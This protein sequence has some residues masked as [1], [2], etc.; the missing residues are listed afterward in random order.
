MAQVVVYKGN[1]DKFDWVTVAQA[2]ARSGVSQRSIRKWIKDRHIRTR[3]NISGIMVFRYGA[4]FKTY[5]R[6]IPVA[7]RV[8]PNQLPGYVEQTPE[9]VEA[10]DGVIEDAL[11]R[12]RLQGAPE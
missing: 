12:S 10:F 1:D 7:R 6:T 11:T 5:N 3:V 9:Q 4:M 2:S 8:Q